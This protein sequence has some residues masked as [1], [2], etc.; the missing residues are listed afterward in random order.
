MDDNLKSLIQSSG[1]SPHSAGY[2]NSQYCQQISRKKLD[3]LAGLVA[4]LEAAV[5]D[6][7]E[8]TTLD[9]VRELDQIQRLVIQAIRRTKAL[10]E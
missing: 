3:N 1:R 8:S 5:A 4:E 9:A 10:N 2:T 7:P 6:Q